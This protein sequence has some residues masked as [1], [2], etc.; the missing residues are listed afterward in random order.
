M[1]EFIPNITYAIRYIRK[2]YTQ[3]VGPKVPSDILKQF[4]ILEFWS[5]YSDRSFFGIDSF[6]PNL[7]KIVLP[8]N[9]DISEDK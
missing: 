6:E 3:A 4:L 9:F 7:K 2:S 1:F 5:I 8:I